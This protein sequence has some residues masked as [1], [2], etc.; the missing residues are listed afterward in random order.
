MSVGARA[1]DWVERRASGEPVAYILGEREFWG[2]ALEV[3]PDAL[4]PRPETE[5][6]VAAALERIGP[7]AR[8]ADLGTGCGAIALAIASERPRARILATDIDMA[9]AALCRRN[10][11]RLQLDA[12]AGSGIAV[13]VADLFDGIGGAF[14]AIVSNPPYV[15][16][17]DPHLH[18]GDLRFEPRVALDGGPCGLR[19]IEHLIREAP[20]HLADGGWLCIEHGC[21]QDH[22][23]RDLFVA[24]GF[25]AI[26]CVPDLERRPRAT[27]GRK[28]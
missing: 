27:V 12:E 13:V 16:T 17:G 9:C 18:L 19:V 21:T 22:E 24:A 2:L 20:A 26:E 4:I 3:T 8:V 1:G 5:T 10:A 11:A 25:D 14:D 28:P 6:L 7:G 23:V 15:A